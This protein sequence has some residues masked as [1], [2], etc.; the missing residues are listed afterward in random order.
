MR[1]GVIVPNFAWSAEP[2]LELA[3]A[4]AAA[5]VDGA[6]AFDHLWPMQA[7]QRPALAPFPLLGAIAARH[8]RLAVGPLVARVG[9]V[10][11]EVLC[12]QFAALD[13]IAPGR[14]IAAMGTGDRLSAEENRAYGV[15]FATS[16]ERRASLERCAAALR[17]LCAEVWIGGGAQATLDLAARQGVTVN[18]WAATPDEVA[19]Q[20]AS[21]T[22]SWAG[23]APGDHGELS[24]LATGLAEAGATWAVFGGITDP[25]RLLEVA[26][27]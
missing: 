7:P 9:L 10:A 26:R 17:H 2:A 11:D 25:E 3:A 22:V 21:T 16:D 15:P 24:D 12:S 13:A 19:S 4:A 5:G 1:I 20:A 27:P 8:P 18:L 6:F 14:V 23:P